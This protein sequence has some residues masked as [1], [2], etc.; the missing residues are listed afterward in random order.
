MGQPKKWHRG[1]RQ[2][3]V[4]EEVKVVWPCGKVKDEPAAVEG[5]LVGG[6]ASRV[7]PCGRRESRRAA[8]R[9]LKWLAFW[10]LVTEGGFDRVEIALGG[11]RCHVLGEMV[12]TSI[13]AGA[14]GEGQEGM[15]LRKI[16]EVKSEIRQRS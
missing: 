8:I 1:E 16:Q 9:R 10:W 3:D 4:Y 11:S 2:F 12:R 15:G 5:R 13:R 14:G 6:K 7:E